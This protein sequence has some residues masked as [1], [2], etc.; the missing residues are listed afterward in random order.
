VDDLAG[1]AQRRRVA[2]PSCAPSTLAR[3]DQRSQLQKR[4]LTMC[5]LL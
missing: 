1:E 2:R 3:R 4:L 5:R